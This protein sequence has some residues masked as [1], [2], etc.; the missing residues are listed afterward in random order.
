MR[1][2]LRESLQLLYYAYFRPSALQAR[3][4]QAA[5]RERSNT[6][7]MH[8]L[9]DLGVT[10]R[11]WRLLWQCVLWWL[12]GLLPFAWLAWETIPWWGIL[13]L[14]VELLT[15]ALFVAMFCLPL[16]LAF[17]LLAGLVW[18]IHPGCWLALQALLRPWVDGYLASVLV[19]DLI[20]GAALAAGGAAWATAQGHKHLAQ[21]IAGLATFV[22]AGV[23]VVVVA[24]PTRSLAT[25]MAAS[26][27]AIVV[28]SLA[29]AIASE[30]DK[31]MW[32]GVAIVAAFGVVFLVTFVVVFEVL[33]DA[34]EM[35]YPFGVALVATFIVAA[36]LGILLL[37]LP[38]WGLICITAVI[39][40]IGVMGWAI[41][42][43]IPAMGLALALGWVLSPLRSSWFGSILAIAVAVLFSVL[44][45][46]STAGLA[47]L[48]VMLGYFR[49]PI[50]SLE[51][52]LV[53]AIA[54]ISRLKTK[55]A[56]A[57]LRLLPPFTDEIVWLPLL[58]LDRLLVAAVQ[59]DQQE[60]EAAIQ[61]V[62]E[63]FH[64]DW[65]VSLARLQLSAWEMARYHVTDQILTAPKEFD[66]LP[67]EPIPSLRGVVEVRRRV[68]GIARQVEAGLS[69]T[70]DYNRLRRFHQAQV[71]VQ[72]FRRSFSALKDRYAQHFSPV[73]EQWEH[74]LDTEISRL[75]AEGEAQ[76][77]IPNP[78]I[79]GIPVQA[80]ETA[81]FAPRPDLVRAVE[82]ALTTR[83]GKP[84]LALYGPR[85]MGKTTFLLHLPRLLPDEVLPVFVDLQAAVRSPSPSGLYYTWA[86]AAS[87]AAHQR[88]LSS[89]P[90]PDW[91][92]FEKKQWNALDEWL[93]A[94]EVS[95]GDRKV[96]FA[97]DE[98]ERLVAVAEREPRMMGV[99]DTL[100][101]LSQHRPQVYLLFAGAHRLEE[102]APGGQWHD[103]FINVHGLEVS[104]LDEAR[105]RRLIT[106]PIEDFPLDYAPGVVDEI[107]HLTRCQPM[108][109][110]L[111]GS[112]LVDWLNS[113]ARRQQGDWLTA[114]LED[115]AYIAQEILHVGRP[116]FA[117]LWADAGE[118][119]QQVLGAAVLTAEGLTLAELGRRTSLPADELRPLLGRLQQYQLVEL[120]EDHWRV[121]VELTRRAFAEFSRG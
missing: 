93:D 107:L 36:V 25:F 81:I 85:R 95:L 20:L 31:E 4:N 86:T 8:I 16:G 56:N 116:Y 9:E 12:L 65:A 75:S 77:D 48:L 104:Y 94:A 54:S 26:V 91:D 64:Q 30:A 19:V 83:Y 100:R 111:M 121:Q 18:G 44:K 88:R 69:A 47:F 90:T 110:Q 46:W 99:F 24:S 67:D 120:V 61:Y 63:S 1:A 114:T 29:A 102:L 119:G 15:G 60:G 70:S 84:T 34:G 112:L 108:L 105:A 33:F 35:A 38:A 118:E 27:A 89:F 59:E 41:L 72:D 21:W 78:Y 117:N 37:F 62:S 66:W 97:F 50:Y 23:A 71:E 32:G 14:G 73:A 40:L 53:T 45:G 11:A 87:K 39:P 22:A 115:V 106:N 92:E 76:A 109:V 52:L 6:D 2:F 10:T 101:H 55:E 103:Y 28:A 80:D 5:P 51:L 43:L 42:P 13:L 7:F 96:F 74:L 98:F 79:T 57:L 17:P 82:S 68:E 58:G 3:L 49:L 113:P